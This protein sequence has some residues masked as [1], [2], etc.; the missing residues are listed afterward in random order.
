MESKISNI[1]E[2]VRQGWKSFLL[3]FIVIF[4]VQ[5]MISF[6]YNPVSKVM[7]PVKADLLQAAKFLN[8][9]F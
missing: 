7:E 4:V 8:S 3:S 9:I 5:I 1:E 2:I 6:N